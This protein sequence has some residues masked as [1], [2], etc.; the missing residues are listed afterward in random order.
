MIDTAL[1]TA[2]PVKGRDYEKRTAKRWKRSEEWDIDSEW[3]GTAMVYVGR[4]LESFALSGDYL[5]NLAD[6]TEPEDMRAARVY[7][8]SQG[9]R[10]SEVPYN[11][12][13]DELV[14]I[15]GAKMTAQKAVSTLKALIARIED[16]GLIVGRIGGGD[17]VHEPVGRELTVSDAQS[18][19]V[20]E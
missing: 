19:D 15:F 20:S 14:V 18:F 7:R 16:D 12:L 2:C 8:A 10:I 1:Q 9:E 3:S 5:V 6:E 13:A 4:S 11:K 17:F